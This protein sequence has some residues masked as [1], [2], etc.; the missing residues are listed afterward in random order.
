MN[1]ASQ[2][3]INE[4]ADQAILLYRERKAGSPKSKE[5]PQPISMTE[6]VWLVLRKKWPSDNLAQRR[7]FRAVLVGVSDLKTEKLIQEGKPLPEK[8]R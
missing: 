3:Q 1:M 5:P 8:Y 7:Q 6:A 4:L 2:D